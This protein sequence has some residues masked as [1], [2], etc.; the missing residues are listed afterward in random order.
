M[1]AKTTQATVP[2]SG[3]LTMGQAAAKLKVTRQA[4]WHAINR[5]RLRC[6]RFDHVVLIPAEALKEYDKSKSKGGRPKK[7]A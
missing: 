4:I 3:V 1:A 5:G 2:L 7:A 6:F